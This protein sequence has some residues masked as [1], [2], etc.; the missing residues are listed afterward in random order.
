MKYGM[1]ISLKRC[2]GCN[3]CSIACKH[4]N[5]T[6]PGVFWRRVVIT[7]SGTYPTSA[8]HALPLLCNHCED[9][10]CAKVCPVGAT[11]IEDNGVVS[12]DSKKCIGCR[13]C[14]TACPYNVRHFVRTNKKGYY[15]DK[16]LTPYEE[17]VYPD[18]KVGT[19]EKCTFC[20]KRVEN[21]GIPACV[22][23]CPAKALFFGDLDDP[24]SEVAKM[25]AT[26]SNAKTLKPEAGSKPKVYYI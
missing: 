23:T 18:H 13:Y 4:E 24:N 6:G 7:E 26:N 10:P 9:A 11:K 20:T 15:G 22:L 1:V 19:V 16:G 5:G 14:M 25:L 12:I 21:G 8:M 17:A 3:S 2:V